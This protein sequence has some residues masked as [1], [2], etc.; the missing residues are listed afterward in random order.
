MGHSRAIR[1]IRE[2]VLLDDL[3]EFHNTRYLGD[4]D[5]LLPTR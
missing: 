5:V 3:S 1:S 4:T 2:I